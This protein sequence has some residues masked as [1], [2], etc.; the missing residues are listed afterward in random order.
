MEWFMSTKTKLYCDDCLT[1]LYLNFYKLSICNVT[2]QLSVRP[3]LAMVV[4]MCQMTPGV[5]SPPDLG[6]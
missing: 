1:C 3:C 6:L 5:P 4:T 2:E